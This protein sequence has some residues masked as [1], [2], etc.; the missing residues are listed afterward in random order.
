MANSH[1]MK[2]VWDIFEN[3]RWVAYNN[4]TGQ[5]IMAKTYD[6]LLKKVHLSH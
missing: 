4:E 6:D 5:Y 3:G 2:N 1:D